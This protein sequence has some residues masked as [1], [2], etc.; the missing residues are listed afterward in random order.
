MRFRA[1]YDSRVRAVLPDKLH[2]FRAEAVPV[3]R[4]WRAGRPTLPGRQALDLAHAAEGAA[5]VRDGNRTADDKGD[6]QGV[7]HLFSRPAFVGSANQM[8]G[9]A[10]IAAQ[11][12]RSHQA[13]KLLCFAAKGPWFVSL[14]VKREE[15]LDA[16]VTATED[17]FVKVGAR[18]LKVV[19]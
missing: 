1:H 7:D 13:Q 15:A 14:V 18:P 10:I 16:K 2:R 12:G 4:R 11:N 17:L 3:Q 5:D 6:V 9:N 19:K 8:V